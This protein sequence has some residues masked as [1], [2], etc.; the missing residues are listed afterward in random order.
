MTQKFRSVC[1]LSSSLE[2]IGDKWSL[3]II[4]DL[5]MGIKTYSD[6]LKSPENIASNN[7]TSRHKQLN[8]YGI[9][10]LVKDQTRKNIKYYYLTEMGKALLSILAEMA[11]WFEKYVHEE[12]KP[13]SQHLTNLLKK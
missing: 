3:L 5:L 7:L 12:E 1:P 8:D 4:R 13:I 11:L 9:I 2:L 6:F 10:Y